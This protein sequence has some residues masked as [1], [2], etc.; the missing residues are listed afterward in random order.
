MDKV[1]DVRQFTQLS[2]DELENVNGGIIPL[3]VVGAFLF[4]AAVGGAVVAGVASV[5]NPRCRC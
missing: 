3:K 4:G 5:L 2:N 1:S